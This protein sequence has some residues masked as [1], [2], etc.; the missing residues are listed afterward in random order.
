MMLSLLQKGILLRDVR[1]TGFLKKLILEEIFQAVRK[2]ETFNIL[3]VPRKV[4]S[5]V[6]DI[7]ATAAKMSI[8]VVRTQ[9]IQAQAKMSMSIEYLH[10]LSP[11]EIGASRDH[12]T[13]FQ[14]S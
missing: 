7:I 9:T 10:S 4:V 12:F 8:E 13:M 3:D 1:S 14:K 11:V 2:L 5:K 6:D